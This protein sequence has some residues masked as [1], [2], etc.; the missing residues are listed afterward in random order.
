MPAESAY[1]CTGEMP[2]AAGRLQSR[3]RATKHATANSTKEG[4][5]FLCYFL[6]FSAY[7]KNSAYFKINAGYFAVR[8]ARRACTA[9]VLT[10]V[11]NTIYI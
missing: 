6:P 7:S 9:G 11:K 3:K 4:Y 10:A 1:S 8:Q 2:K 5:A